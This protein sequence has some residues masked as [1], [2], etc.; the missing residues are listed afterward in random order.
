M[1]KTSIEKEKIGRAFGGH[2]RKK[3]R[4]DRKREPLIWAACD[5]QHL[6]G[7]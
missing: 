1:N 4:Q 2:G 3:E 5:P 7:Y 6:I